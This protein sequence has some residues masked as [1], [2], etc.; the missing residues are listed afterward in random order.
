[1]NN[2]RDKIR[3]LTGLHTAL[4]GLLTTINQIPVNG[5]GS[6]GDDYSTDEKV[7]GTWIDGKP[8]YRKVIEQTINWSTSTSYVAHNISHGIP[9]L[10]RVINITACGGGRGGTQ[11]P[12]PYYEN[13]VVGTYIEV[14]NSSSVVIQNK[15][16]WTNCI[17]S[18]CIEY[19]KITD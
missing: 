3:G 17:L 10:K 18:I 19:T 16:G 1:M 4:E 15:T 9:N 12:I 5:G 13:S 11:Y 8:L 7:I 14:V 2:F 6:S